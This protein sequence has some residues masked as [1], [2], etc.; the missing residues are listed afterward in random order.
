MIPGG[1]FITAP[2]TKNSILILRK[3]S[4]LNY[5][6][7]SYAKLLLPEVFLSYALLNS[8]LFFRDYTFI[9]ASHPQKQSLQYPVN[10]A[11]LFRFFFLLPTHLPACL[12]T[13]LF[14]LKDCR[15]PLNDNH[16]LVTVFHLFNPIAIL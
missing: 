7:S 6:F 8:F 14:V 1:I 11:K 9:P 3:K 4:Q 5:I 2:D 15:F 13:L 16:M 10:F 12:N